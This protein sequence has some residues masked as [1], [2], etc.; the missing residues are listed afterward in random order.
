[1]PFVRPSVLLVLGLIGSA[2]AEDIAEVAGS[3]Y[4]LARAINTHKSLDLRPVW[5][6][7]SVNTNEIFMA[8]C[9]EE[10][11]G[12]ASCTSELIM[13]TDPRQVIL[14]IKDGISRFQVFLR[15]KSVGADS[16][17]FTG[18]FMPFVKYFHLEHRVVRFG[19][20]P[21]LVATEQGE[22]G[23]GLSSKLENWLDLTRDDLRPALSFT[24]E[25]D[26]HPALNRIGSRTVGV[27]TKLETQPVERATI[28]FS[29]E[30]L[31]RRMDQEDIRIGRRSDNVVYRRSQAGKFEVDALLSTATVAEIRKFYDELDSDPSPEE[32]L[33]FDLNGLVSIATG[34]D[35]TARSWLAEFLRGSPDTAES[36]RLKALLHAPR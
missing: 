36:R 8:S 16:W 24:T 10:G 30:F 15:Y 11:S 27:V 1:M 19:A 9:G 5:K 2:K 18:A 3:P 7:L 26:F 29:V 6:A 23:T 20:K 14:V 28:R 22:A 12:A 34:K 33:Q 17:R 31:A 4:R 21:F 32:F 35:A 13:V 25:G